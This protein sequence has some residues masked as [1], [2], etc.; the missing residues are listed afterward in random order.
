LGWAFGRFKGGR[1]NAGQMNKDQEPKKILFIKAMNLRQITLIIL[2][3]NG[4]K[5]MTQMEGRFEY[6]KIDLI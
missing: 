6:F 2:K 3:E 1:E 5:K 4:S